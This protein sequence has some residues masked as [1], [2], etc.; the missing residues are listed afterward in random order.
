M[1][2]PKPIATAPQDGSTVMV[3]WTDAAGQE[4]E[5][6]ARYRSPERL[7][8]AGGDWD[9]SEAGWWVFTDGDTQKRV[10]PHS[11]MPATGEG[12]AD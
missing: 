7:R 1:T 5:S 12:N 9:E 6:P 4:N 11:W 10:E 2:S 8:A 3:R